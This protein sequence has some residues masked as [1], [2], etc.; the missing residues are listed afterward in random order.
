MKKSFKFLGILSFVLAGILI[1]L[2]LLKPFKGTKLS[3]DYETDSIYENILAGTLP[4]CNSKS[5]EENIFE[6]EIDPEKEK[7]FVIDLKKTLTEETLIFQINEHKID[8]FYSDYGKSIKNFIADVKKL[9]VKGYNCSIY[10]VGRADSTGQKNFKR[11]LT[12]PL[13]LKIHKSINNDKFKFSSEF[14][15]I[16]IPDTF[17]NNHLPELRSWFL[18]QQVENNLDFEIKTEILEGKVENQSN[19]MFR[20]STIILYI[21][22]P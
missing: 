15:E 2:L 9:K 20:N 8:N 13:K 7:Y 1:I 21:E 11:T 5:L 10:F 16:T 4:Y 18:K 12:E 3:L 19:A 22:K 17:Y 6:G 14:T